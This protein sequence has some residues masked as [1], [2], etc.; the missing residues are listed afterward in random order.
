[1]SVYEKPFTD[2]LKYLAKRVVMLAA[3]LLGFKS[4]CLALAT[5]LLVRRVITEDVWQTVMIT[6]I[7]AA[8]GLRL[9][10]AYSAA[11][12]ARNASGAAFRTT[13]TEEEHTDEETDDAPY[14]GSGSVP[15][16][17]ASSA[18]AGIQRAA[19][20]GKERIRALL[21]AGSAGTG[22][23]GDPAPAAG[24]ACS[25]SGRGPAGTAGAH[26]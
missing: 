21:A 5:V 12:A 15:V 7:C 16:D 3:K 13:G 23:A 14:E 26:P 18:G 22:R 8:G 11:A 9:A 19:A 25:G 1:M 2:V 17:S 20:E 10:D 6:V 4:F 24:T